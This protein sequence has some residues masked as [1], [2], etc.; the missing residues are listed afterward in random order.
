MPI[1]EQ[2]ER[3]EKKDVGSIDMVLKANHKQKTIG[4]LS[5][6]TGNIKLILEQE[7]R[8]YTKD[9]SIVYNIL[10]ETSKGR[11]YFLK[12]ADTDPELIPLDYFN[13]LSK[14]LET[15]KKVIYISPDSKKGSITYA[16]LIP[17]NK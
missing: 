1:H 15:G 5:V 9:S 16:H 14:E 7:E 10:A 6:L 17:N 2:A 12:F 4:N 13:Q 11:R 3:I 8:E